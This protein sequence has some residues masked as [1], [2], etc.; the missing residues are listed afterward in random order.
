[1]T[2][3]PVPVPHSRSKSGFCWTH[4]SV[5]YALD[6]FHRRHLRTPTLRELRAGVEDMPSFATIKRLYGNAGNMLRYH[7]YRVRSAGAQP[8]RP[9]THARD[10]RGWFLPKWWPC[11]ESLPSSAAI[12]YKRG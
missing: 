4:E 2:T 7:G 1:M 10:E 11:E 5:G 8:G 3:S 6:R 12:S 9:C